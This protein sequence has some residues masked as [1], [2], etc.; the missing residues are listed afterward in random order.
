MKNLPDGRITCKGG[1][2]ISITGSDT[3]LL[4]AVESMTDDT[5]SWL[6]INK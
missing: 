5:P 1:A 6:K 3:G 4:K 2:Y